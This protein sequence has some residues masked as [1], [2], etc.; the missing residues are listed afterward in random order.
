MNSSP[1]HKVQ[2]ILAAN[3]KEVAYL[4]GFLWADGYIYK[5]KNQS[6]TIRLEF[7]KKDYLDIKNQINKTGYWPTYYRIRKN[8]K[9]QAT[10]VSSNRHLYNF[11]N[12]YDY[13]LKQNPIPIIQLIPE[14]LRPFWYLGFLDGDGCIYYNEET[15]ASQ[16]TFSGKYNQN[17][18]FIK[19]L[20]KDVGIENFKISRINTSKRKYS[21]VRLSRRKDILKLLNYLY[22]WPIGL[23]RKFIKY[24]ELK[25]K[26]V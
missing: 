17:W 23:K 16:L 14:E 2:N 25:S 10:F 4:L 26:G 12:K 1:L 19:N 7:L 13:K 24:E 21:Y 18:S 22:K 8:R 6:V 5:T 3:T 15:S 9:P 20:L 11:L